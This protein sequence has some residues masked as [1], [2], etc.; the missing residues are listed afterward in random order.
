M[1]HG[2][3]SYYYTHLVLLNLNMFLIMV[4]FQTAGLKPLVDCE[5]NVHNF[6]V[7]LEFF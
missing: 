7:Q 1:L 3:P 2:I 4:V 6:G 5:K